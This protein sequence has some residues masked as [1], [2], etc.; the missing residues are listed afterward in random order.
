[1]TLDLLNLVHASNPT[2]RERTFPTSAEWVG[3]STN[4]ARTLRGRV[5]HVADDLV[6]SMQLLA[7]P[8]TEFEPRARMHIPNSGEVPPDSTLAR[9]RDS[10]AVVPG[11][12]NSDRTTVTVAELLIP[13]TTDLPIGGA[14]EELRGSETF[15]GQPDPTPRNQGLVDI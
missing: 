2:L 13:R 6:H 8:C 4:Q 9:I 3:I 15:S 14:H 5:T 11:Q 1:M 10:S 12:H 7:S